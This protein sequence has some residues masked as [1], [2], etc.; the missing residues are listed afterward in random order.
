MYLS[1][2][3]Q[4]VVEFGTTE[5]VLNMSLYMFML[6]FTISILFL[7][8]MSDK[9]GRRK[10]LIASMIIYTASCFA[11]CFSV[12]VG[13]FIA[14][15]IIEAIGAGGAISVAFALVKDC[16]SGRNMSSILSLVAVLGILGPILSPVIGTVL[17]NS[18]DWKATFWAPAAI[19]ALC[20][21]LGMMLSGNIPV[22]RMNGTMRDA[23][24][25]IFGLMKERNFFD[26][27]LM[28][29][30]FSAS[31]LAFIAV[32]SYVFLQ[33]Y[34]L[35]RTQYSLA[36]AASCVIGL[37][38]AEIIKRIKMNS[39]K[40]VLAMFLL[41]ALSFVMML[42]TPK[43]GWIWFM[44]SITPN[45]AACTI[46]R[47]F[48]FN[49]LM[50]NHEGDNGAVSSLL[51]FMT[52]LFAFIG[53]AVASSFPSDIFTYAIAF[54]MFFMTLLYGICWFDLKRQTPLK[55]LE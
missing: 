25:P 37:I 8:P 38:L 40:V 7:G 17:I 47:S 45:S 27:T 1:G 54:V 32:S 23:V 49:I 31:Q 9:Y 53:M 6:S 41:S 26:F 19:S 24:R 15:R 3:P 55:G 52:F 10:I 30:S 16:F 35:D 28:L 11:C 34:G 43:Y 33:D 48:G 12:N 50:N 21:V 36:L 18:I 46:T 2:L 42:T 29:T 5:S 22:E 14:L 51:N 39:N 4:M 13:M 20:I 44:L